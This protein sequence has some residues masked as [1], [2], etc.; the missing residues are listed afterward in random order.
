MIKTYTILDYTKETGVKP[1][2]WRRV[3]TGVRNTGCVVMHLRSSGGKCCLWEY[4]SSW[5]RDFLQM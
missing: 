1:L 3:V 2:G 4:I 5:Y